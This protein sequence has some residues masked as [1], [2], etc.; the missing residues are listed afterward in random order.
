MNTLYFITLWIEGSDFFQNRKNHKNGGYNPKNK[1]M[2]VTIYTLTANLISRGIVCVHFFLTEWRLWML[3]GGRLVNVYLF[4][5]G[6]EILEI[7][8]WLLLVSGCWRNTLLYTFIREE[9]LTKKILMRLFLKE[10]GVVLIGNF[11]GWVW[12]LFIT[13]S[14]V[15]V[16]F[17]IS[18]FM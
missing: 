6:S 1:Q 14:F 13:N 9:S 16:L 12:L 3:I 18:W 5:I 7:A 2:I 11:N 10:M 8:F 17:G 4:C 15:F